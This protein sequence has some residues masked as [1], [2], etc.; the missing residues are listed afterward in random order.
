MLDTVA[1]L[2]GILTAAIMAI[3][4]VLKHHAKLASWY[5]VVREKL[6]DWYYEVYCFVVRPG[7][8]GQNATVSLP[9]VV[10]GRISVKHNPYTGEYETSRVDFKT[11][12]ARHRY[13]E[14]RRSLTHDDAGR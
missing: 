8:K 4:Y 12:E 13:M 6:D 7:K 2:L 10:V 3:G 14:Y 9:I 1:N 5:S 11:D